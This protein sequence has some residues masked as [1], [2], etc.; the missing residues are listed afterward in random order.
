MNEATKQFVIR[1]LMVDAGVALLLL[2]GTVLKYLD[3]RDRKRQQQ[4]R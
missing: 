2:W 1:W 4:S 3:R